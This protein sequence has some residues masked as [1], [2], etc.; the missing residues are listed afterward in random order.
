MT[1]YN[2]QSTSVRKC[3]ELTVTL[4]HSIIAVWNVRTSPELKLAT[5]MEPP[6]KLSELTLC[7][8]TPEIQS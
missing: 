2:S 7:N 5:I 6:H 4:P 1:L 8:Q 3:V